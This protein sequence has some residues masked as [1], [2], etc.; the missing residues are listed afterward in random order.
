MIIAAQHKID[1]PVR[2]ILVIQLGDIGDVVWAIPAFWALKEAFPRAE[3]FVL[4]RN[5]NGDFLEDDARIDHVLKVNGKH[6]IGNLRLLKNIRREKFDL[7]F[8]LR[9]DDRGAFLSFF[10][11]ALIRA[12]LH[13]GN[14]PW[15]NRAFTHLVDPSRI[16]EEAFGAAQQSLQIL[17]AFGIREQ[18][19]KP[20]MVVA[21]QMKSD[22]LAL[23]SNE[24]VQAE[25]GWISVNPFSRWLYKEWQMGNWRKLASFIWQTYRMPFIITGS[26]EEKKRADELTAGCDFPIYN[27]AGKTTIRHMAA[28]L[29]M[30]RLHIGVDSAAPHIAAAVGTPTI[31]IYGPSDWRYWA[32]TGENHRVVLPD[33]ECVPCRSKGCEGKGRSVCLDELP[34]S[35]VQSATEAML[36]RILTG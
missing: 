11:G 6:E 28:L 21:E 30:S 27:F 17:H 12:A 19:T 16:K 9:A 14:L 25:N 15:R 26:M 8:D 29:R 18:T 23:L 31:T 35:K 32:P 2:K 24:N 34:V 5:H 36:K 20:V 7:L 4:V 10:S 13:Y 33:K 3:L 1:S 22:I